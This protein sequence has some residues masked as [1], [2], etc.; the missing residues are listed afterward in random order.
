MKKKILTKKKIRER[1]LWRGREFWR[2]R[3]FWRRR[4]FKRKRK[5]WWRRQFVQTFKPFSI[6]LLYCFFFP[7]FPFSAD[8][9]HPVCSGFLAPKAPNVPF[10]E[11]FRETSRLKKMFWRQRCQTSRFEKI[12]GAEGAKRPVSRKFSALRAPRDAKR[13]VWKGFLASKAS[14]VPFRENFLVPRD[15]KRPVW[16]KVLAPSVPYRENVQRCGHHGTRNV[17]L[18]RDFWRQRRRTSRFEKNVW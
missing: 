8:A 16:R 18:E 17:P 12:F 5:F 13:P 9:K 11:N 4:K 10:R 3:K 1:K 15:A 6:G 2:G 7:N 14:N